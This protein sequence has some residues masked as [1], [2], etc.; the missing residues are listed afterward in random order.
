MVG[1]P[2]FTLALCWVGLDWNWLHSFRGYGGTAL[3]EDA[4]IDVSKINSVVN[5][6]KKTSAPSRNSQAQSVLI[7]YCAAGGVCQLPC[8]HVVGIC[9][10]RP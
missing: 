9:C 3:F 6:W 10:G 8:T 1:N 2:V 5:D 4:G 7:N